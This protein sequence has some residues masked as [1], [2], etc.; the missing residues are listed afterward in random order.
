VLR[1]ASLQITSSLDLEQVLYAMLESAFN[2]VGD[3][4]DANIFLYEDGKLRFGAAIFDDGRRGT[5]WAEPR[6]DGLTYM[7]ARTG[8]VV[9]VEDMSTHP[10][11]RTAPQEWHGAIIG[12]PLSYG[13]KVL[14]VM[15]MSWPMPR[16][17]DQEELHAMELLADQAAIAIENARLH[18]IVQGEAM[19][20]ALTGLPNRRAFDKNLAE[21]IRRSARYNHTFT[22]MMVD[23]DGYKRIN[24]TYGHV[25]G[26]TALREIAQCLR[27]SVRDTDFMAR[28]G[29]D[30]FVL[31]LPETKSGDDLFIAQK[32]R[33]AAGVC[34]LS[35]PD[36][37]RETLT[38][39]I[40]SASFPLDASEP[41]G[42]IH[43][44][45]R[46]LYDEKK[47]HGH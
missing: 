42:L 36:G 6:Q 27:G 2:L 41:S 29:G 23:L 14:G 31:I 40:G 16:K 8:D 24:D 39:S 37:K 13:G 38:L 4:R 47:R 25:V 28:F 20:D 12:L 46:L 19:T 21:E 17:F 44:A 9:A 43:E 3:T 15:N 10:L 11:F 26:D 33:E 7:V 34:R 5:P 22:V 18:R 1:K 45:D 30:E 35:L 32:L